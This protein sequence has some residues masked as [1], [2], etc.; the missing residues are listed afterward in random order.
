MYV[1]FVNVHDYHFITH[2]LMVCPFCSD[3]SPMESLISPL[4]SGDSVV[5]V[6]KEEK[7]EEEAFLK[8]NFESLSSA[9]A[10]V[11]F[12]TSHSVADMT[13]GRLSISTKFLSKSLE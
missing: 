13:S 2:I 11:F 4:C 8:T 9:N 3:C 10:D 5:D 12:G 7:E 6:S 1:G